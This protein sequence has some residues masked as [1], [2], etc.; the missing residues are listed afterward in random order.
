MISREEYE[1]REEK[2]L[3]PY[4]ALSGKSRGRKYEEPLCPFRSMFQRDRDRIVHCQAFRRLEYKTQ[5]FVNH[6]GDYYRT[7]LT[8]TLEVAQISR[9]LARTLR[10]N[11]DLA[12]AIALAHDLGH[13]PFGHRGEAAL[14]SLMADEGGFEHNRQ[15]YRVVTL[16]EKRYP[17]FPGLNLSTETLEG[18]VKHVGEYDSPATAG[19][20]VSL[21]SFPSLEAQVVNVA[22]EIAYM[23]HDLDDGLESGMLRAEDLGQVS[24]WQEANATARKGHPDLGRRLSKYG[25]IRG[26]IHMLVT[27]LQAETKRRI[28]GSGVDSI[29]D[30]GKI[31]EPLV[32]FSAEMSVRTKQLKDFLFANLYRHYLVERMADKSTRILSALFHTYLN[33]PKVLPPRLER[34]IR[35]EGQACRRICDYIAGMTD[36]YALSEYAKLFDPN[37]RV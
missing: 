15:S 23:N 5:V 36:R 6:E 32:A 14:N 34:T 37:E 26:I 18:I 29:D 2:V 30:L 25:T 4:A 10:L 31:K 8:H 1:S 3:A 21:T 12:E 33:N 22:D 27:D 13:T 19:M 35:E 7:R 9:G 11:E 28:E 20:D 17:D 24:I 16:L